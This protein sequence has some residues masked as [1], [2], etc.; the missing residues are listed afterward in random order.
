MQGV[1]KMT[2]PRVATAGSSATRKRALVVVPDK[3]PGAAP[4]GAARAAL[5]EALRHSRHHPAL[6]AADAAASAHI[7]LGK[8]P[9]AVPLVV[10]PADKLSGRRPKPTTRFDPGHEASRP[11]HEASRPQQD[12]PGSKWS[13][14]QPDGARPPKLEKFV[15]QDIC[16]GP[17]GRLIDLRVR[18]SCIANRLSMVFLCGAQGA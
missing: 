14:L 16:P 6:K 17:P 12:D 4:L 18:K 11:Q 5:K 15:V 7:V 1:V 10:V 8:A 2:V 13:L 3:A 9:G